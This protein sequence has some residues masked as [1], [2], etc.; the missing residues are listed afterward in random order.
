MTDITIPGIAECAMHRDVTTTSRLTR[1]AS[2]TVT[3]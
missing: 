2:N 3:H 1:D